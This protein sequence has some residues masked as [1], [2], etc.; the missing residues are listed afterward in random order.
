MNEITRQEIETLLNMRIRELKFYQEALIHKSAMKIYNVSRSN[1][2]LEFIGD[3]VLNLIVTRYV[4]DKYPDE[5]E[6]FLTKIR[7]KIVSGKTLSNI[8]QKMK[9]QDA[10]RMNSKALKQNWNSNPR[11]L[12][13]TLESLIGAIY[14]DMGI[15][16]VK[17]F[18]ERFIE[19]VVNEKDFFKDNNFKDILMR[20]T[21]SLNLPLPI[22]NTVSETGPDHKKIFMVSVTVNSEIIGVG[23]GKIKKQAE[24]IAAQNALQTYNINE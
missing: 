9:I 2:R 11:I 4:Y 5:N 8:A 16:H 23:K 15:Y 1:E 20:H 14:L 22:Y 7:M 17:L 18:I 19:Q 3:A 6:G 10:I 13:D 24:Q 12:E 21:Q